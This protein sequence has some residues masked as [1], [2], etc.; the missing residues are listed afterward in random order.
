[1]TS[2]VAELVATTPVVEITPDC[3][4]LADVDSECTELVEIW[5]D[6]LL[7][8][9]EVTGTIVPNVS[10]SIEKDAV[11]TELG[12]EIVTISVYEELK[13]ARLDELAEDVT[14]VVLA[15]WLFAVLYFTRYAV[16]APNYQHPYS[17]CALALQIY[18]CPAKPTCQLEHDLA[19]N[20]ANTDILRGAVWSCG[21][22]SIEKSSHRSKR[23]LT[24]LHASR[25]NTSPQKTD[26]HSPLPLGCG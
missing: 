14:V 6:E 5:L 3:E 10:L 23:A 7:D 1:M 19:R 2:N 13:M 9:V 8:C 15:D 12:V 26:L 11:S 21:I 24:Q 18:N 16:H 20:P 25:R 4:K 17:A 22:F